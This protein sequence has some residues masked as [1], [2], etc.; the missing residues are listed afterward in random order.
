VDP[1]HASDLFSLAS[2]H[3]VH[4]AVNYDI[5]SASAAID[6]NKI[7]QKAAKKAAGGGISGAL[8]GVTQVLSLMW[9]RT[10]MNYQYR[11]GT[12]TTQT[13]KT[14]LSQGGIGRLYRGVGYALVQ[15]PLSR[16]GD[17]AANA[18]ILAALEAI[19]D[20]KDL[21]LPVKQGLA[22]LAASSWRVAITPVD[23]LK[24]TLQVEGEEAMKQL[25]SK[26]KE[27]GVGVLW[28]GAFAAA[29]ATFVG[30]YPWF[31]T[32]NSLDSY[33]PSA[34][35]DDILASL[36]R[37][38]LLGVCASCVSDC[39]SNSL[40]VIKTTKQTSKV[41]ISYIDAAKDVIEKDGLG[42]LFVRGLETRIL[43]NCIQGAL[44]AVTWKYFEKA[45]GV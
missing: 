10:T 11:Y 14:L 41:P 8:A 12:N 35:A 30:N 32:Y 18:G 22:S 34:D 2:L 42:G 38:A 31:L 6:Y 33:I 45:L 43:V 27:G 40:R 36:G 25:K 19:D 3:S 1:Q 15:N 28:N 44:F 16:F 29:A 17:T 39:S 7:F 20:T 21:P 23:T 24:T 5:A 37:R 9:L 4:S 26:V 13:L